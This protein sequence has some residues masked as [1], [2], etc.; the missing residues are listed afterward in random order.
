MDEVPEKIT[1]EDVLHLVTHHHYA[2][3]SITMSITYPASK[4]ITISVTYPAT[5]FITCPYHGVA[6]GGLRPVAAEDYP[7]ALGPHVLLWHTV[8]HHRL[9]GLRA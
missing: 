2:I 9:H 8:R 1:Y 5:K 3:K 6:G 4:F 7:P